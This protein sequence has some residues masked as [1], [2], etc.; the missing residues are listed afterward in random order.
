MSESGGS[1]VMVGWGRGWFCDVSQV[2][3]SRREELEMG[4]WELPPI[5]FGIDLWVRGP[6][7]TGGPNEI[8]TNL[9]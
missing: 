4:N 2:Q 8:F 7:L 6:H 1:Q 5:G 3:G 9:W